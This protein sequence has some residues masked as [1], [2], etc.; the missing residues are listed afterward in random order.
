[1]TVLMAL[2]VMMR[3]VTMMIIM[4]KRVIKAIES[5]FAAALS[6]VPRYEASQGF[7][8]LNLQIDQHGNKEDG[9]S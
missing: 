6:G 9:Q 8:S 1:M 4:L 2:K 7:A 3:M 5:C